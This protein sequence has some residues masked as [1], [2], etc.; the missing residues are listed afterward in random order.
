MP[1]VLMVAAE[2]APFAKTG[3]LADV[4]G[5]LPPSLIKLGEQVRWSCRATP[6][7][8]FP[9]PERIWDAM[10]LFIGPHV[11]VVAIDQIIAGGVRYCL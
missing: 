8:K 7:L 11:F 1:R 6:P 2:A 4:M 3:G 5:S 10:P 9:M